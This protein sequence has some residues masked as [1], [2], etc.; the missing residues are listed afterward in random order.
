MSAWFGQ[1]IE[2]KWISATVG[3]PCL[4]IVV[5]GFLLY[6]Q[7]ADRYNDSN[8]SKRTIVGNGV[9]LTWAPRGARVPLKGCSWNEAAD[10]CSRLSEDGLSLESSPVGVW[11]L[12]TADE[13]VRSL[14]KSNK[15][16]VGILDMQS[17]RPTYQTKPDKESPVWDIYSPIIYYWTST[18][19]DSTKAF[20]IVY[21]GQVV[22]RS[23]KWDADY[24]SFRAV[25]ST[26]LD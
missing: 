25:K 26:T 6:S 2:W 8:F 1:K 9:T 11:R 20:I 3:L 5:T 12:P 21:N 10:I 17:M 23:K 4:F 16:S 19:V 15:N 13:A 24:L 14:S 22:K 18:E 7:I